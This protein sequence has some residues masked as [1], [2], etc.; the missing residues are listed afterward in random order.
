MQCSDAQHQISSRLD[1][2]LD[3]AS[4]AALLAHL[5]ACPPCSA[6]QDDLRALGLDAF[7]APEPSADFVS[8]IERQL[9]AARPRR[10]SIIA[11]RA[12]AGVLG[13]A[14]TVAGFS[15]GLRLPQSDATTIANVSPTDSSE[16]IV[17]ESINPFGEN[18]VEGVLL[19]MIT[20]TGE[21]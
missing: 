19:A 11:Y 2:E 14:A 4:T 21:G 13:L 3:P 12:A 1:N 5:S 18:T 20:E 17:R 10:M 9:A 6:Y 16:A 8:R 15:I 7:V